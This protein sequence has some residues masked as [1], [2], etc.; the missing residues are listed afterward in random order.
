MRTHISTLIRGRTVTLPLDQVTHFTSGDKYVTAHHAG[1]QLVI[2][3]TLKALESELSDFIRTHRS[4]L[5]RRSLIKYVQRV[6][7][8][9]TVCKLSGVNE[10]LPVSELRRNSVKALVM[11]GEQ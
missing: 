6:D 11:S 10:L 3:D 5:V 8:D 9:N 4:V 2:T 7:C 1:G